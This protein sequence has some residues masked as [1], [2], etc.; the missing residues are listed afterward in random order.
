MLTNEGKALQA[1]VLLKW[2]RLTES[3]R[4]AGLCECALLLRLDP[5]LDQTGRA[6]RV[7]VR[8]P[9]APAGF[10]LLMVPSRHSPAIQRVNKVHPRPETTTRPKANLGSGR[11]CYRRFPVTQP[12]RQ[13]FGWKTFANPRTLSSGRLARF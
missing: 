2:T 8:S 13:P 10:V 4:F 6:Q 12:R 5:D 3:A 11:T 7:A 9:D 1:A